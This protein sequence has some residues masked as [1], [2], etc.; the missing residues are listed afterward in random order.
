MDYIH[1]LDKPPRWARSWCYLYLV[2]AIGLA[3]FAFLLLIAF[4]VAF[5]AIKKKGVIGTMVIYTG[6]FVLQALSAMVIF[7]MCRTS[8]KD[9]AD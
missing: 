6:A 5:D 3:L 2:A 7:W 4:I 1:N 9:T 8:L